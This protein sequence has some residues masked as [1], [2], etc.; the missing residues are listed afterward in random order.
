[1]KLNKPLL[2]A[3]VL[4]TASV[5][6]AQI[7]QEPANPGNF[8]AG[9][10][11]KIDMI[12]IHK[13]EGSASSCWNWFQNPASQVSAH[14]VV[15]D[16]GAVTQ[17]VPDADT[18]WHAGNWDYNCRSIGIENAGFTAENDISD[19]H[20]KAL[21][22][23]CRSLCDRYGIPKDRQHII[24]HVEVPQS[25]HTDPGH[26]FSWPTFM[27]Y[28]NTGASN[29]ALATR[30]GATVSTGAPAATP[31]PASGNG[32][33]IQWG[34]CLSVL[35]ERF[36]T[37]VAAIL[38]VNP[39]ITNPDLIF[40]GAKLTLPAGVSGP[41]VFANQVTNA[42]GAT[43]E[44]V[45]G[46]DKALEFAQA[47]PEPVNPITGKRD[48]AHN[49]SGVLA[50]YSLTLVNA[51]FEHA[52][53]KVP[54]LESDTAHDAFLLFG[55]AGKIHKLD[56]NNSPPRGAV[57]FFDSTNATGVNVGIA[58]IGNGDWS[59]TAAVPQNGTGGTIQKKCALN[60]KTA[61]GWA[62]PTGSDAPPAA[63][64]PSEPSDAGASLIQKMIDKANWITAQ[65]YAYLWGGGH[66]ASFS[67][68]YDCSGSVS[69]VL[70]AAGLLSSPEVSGEME[71]FGLPGPGAVTLYANAEHVYMSINGRFF[72]TSDSNP[73]GGAAWFNGAPRPG[74]VVRHVP[75]DGK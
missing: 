28:L 15:D 49:A 30:D 8:T 25:T 12:V 39:E 9:R 42:A 59:F 36:G 26:F 32:Y 55:K 21:A 13:A 54:E 38:A 71:T 41:G 58:G 64:T 19:T 23:L 72:G 63:A 7:A 52:G 60:L 61:L 4:A 1:M 50:G 34:D 48:W 40:A 24:G 56:P 73:G 16:N 57:I 20:M 74:F 31:A 10:S 45:P 2:A 62:N 47:T 22:A 43:K 3:L 6:Q 27:L 51:A 35:A 17:M 67:G 5:A 14:Y 29:P 18:A 37:S 53:F 46:A 11:A 65:H 75:I 68:P 33:T 69:A 44:T 66:N 70:H